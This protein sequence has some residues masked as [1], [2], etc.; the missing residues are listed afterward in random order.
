MKEQIVITFGD[1]KILSEIKAA[2]PERDLVLYQA[3]SQQ[4]EFMLLDH[5]GQETVFKSPVYYDILSH[6]GTD[7]WNGFISFSTLDLNFEEQKVF[8]ARINRLRTNGLPDGMHSMYSLN[9][10]KD[11]SQRIILGTWNAY[12]DYE[13]W[14]N[15]SDDFIPKEYRDS[16]NFYSHE[17]YY[18][19][20]KEKE[21]H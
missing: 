13:L 8:D 11:I 7:N 1:E 21:T 4:G 14:K 18:T 2:H 12:S 3:L 15:S 10:H 16:P 5:S 6:A 17:A 9:Y 20:A 19:P